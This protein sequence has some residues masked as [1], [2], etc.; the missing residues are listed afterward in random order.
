MENLSLYQITNGFMELMN[1]I[2]TE[3]LTDEEQKEIEE[4]LTEALQKKSN[5]IIGYIQNQE[6]L[7]KAIDEQ[8]KRLQDFKKHKQNN[9][10]K[11]KEYVKGNMNTL[12]IIKFETPIGSLLV[13]KSP[14]SVEIVN[15]DIIPEDYKTE[16]KT[17]KIDKKKIADDFK[18]TG[19]LIDGVII[20][21]DNTNLRV[22]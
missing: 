8:I 20:H 12:G 1:K 6:A 17:I 2:E 11:F 5:N 4:V 19:E 15:E 14:I 21:T 9:L 10:D 22:K 13:A 16:V 7:I 3:E 18:A